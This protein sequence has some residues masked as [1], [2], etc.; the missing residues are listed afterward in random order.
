MS[1]KTGSPDFELVSPITNAPKE[2]RKIPFKFYMFVS[3]NNHFLYNIENKNMTYIFINYHLVNT[4]SFED[5][6]KNLCGIGC[7][8]LRTKFPFLRPAMNVALK[9]DS[10][11]TK[12]NY[13]KWL[14]TPDTV[15]EVAPS[16][17]ICNFN[18]S[19]DVLEK[20][21]TNS[22]PFCFLPIETIKLQ[23]IST[24]AKLIL[25]RLEKLLV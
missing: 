6:I 25:E 3:A 24:E 7:K 1:F 17:T 4:K 11:Q 23:S 2:E 22:K 16:M 5:Q 18:I 14:S 8:D 21:N 19:A 20:I 12:K 13:D 9:V 10:I 15:T